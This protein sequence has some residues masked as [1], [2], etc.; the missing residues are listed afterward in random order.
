[1]GKQ[2]Q[3]LYGH[4]TQEEKD[5]YAQMFGH[6]FTDELAQLDRTGAQIQQVE[7]PRAGEAAR[8]AAG[9]KKAGAYC[10]LLQTVNR[11][12]QTFQTQNYIREERLGQRT[13]LDSY[14]KGLSWL[15]DVIKGLDDKK[16]EAFSSDGYRTLVQSGREYRQ[17]EKSSLKSL[18]L[19]PIVF[20]LIWFGLYRL[21]TADFMPGFLAKPVWENISYILIIVICIGI[22][23]VCLSAGAGFIGSVIAGVLITGVLAGGSAF[24]MG[25]FLKVVPAVAPAFEQAD[26]YISVLFFPLLVILV[27]ATV[28]MVPPAF[29]NLKAVGKGAKMRARL[30]EIRRNLIKVSW[31]RTIF[32][33][34]LETADVCEDGSGSLTKYSE[35]EAAEI[36][37]RVREYFTPLCE[38]FDSA[39]NAVQAAK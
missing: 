3:Y 30:E 10:P 36:I 20:A 25:L 12:L 29:K 38:D 7:L 17:L 28:A 9:K 18:F 13:D 11:A 31:E 37:K 26:E 23:I 33:V 2:Y 24:G 19:T 4:L 35:K 34:I 22:I 8:N 39:K 6:E 14:M 15:S 5:R 21:F 32:G 1:M 16:H 27:I